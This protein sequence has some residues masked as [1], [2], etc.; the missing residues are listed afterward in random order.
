[1]RT[2]VAVRTDLRSRQ[3]NSKLPDSRTVADS[4][5]GNICEFVYKYALFRL[6]HSMTLS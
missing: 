6:S 2:D 5:R 3:N 4:F 1:M